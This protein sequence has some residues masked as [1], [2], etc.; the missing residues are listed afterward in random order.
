M[1][2][3]EFKNVFSISEKQINTGRLKE[4]YAQLEAELVNT[5][6]D[7]QYNDDTIWEIKASALLNDL[8][9][10][11][12]RLFKLKEK[13]KSDE[14]YI[15]AS[16][17]TRI[18]Q[19][20]DKLGGNE[21]I[22][23][24]IEDYFT[25]KDRVQQVISMADFEKDELKRQFQKIEQTESSFINSKNVSVMEARLRQLEELYWKGLSNTTSFLI[26][27]FIEYK[28]YTAAEFKDYYAAKSIMKMADDALQK[29][30]YPEFRRH[31]FSISALLHV[32][33]FNSNID[34]KGTGI[35]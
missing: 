15:I 6:R 12:D 11:K 8:R 26:T 33:R 16:R 2:Q 28:T 24:L 7:F 9:S 20:Y 35:G 23:M 19:E 14:K 4:Q 13:D 10:V 1:T 25:N 22:A 3:Q 18:S 17:I 21:R 5:V 30:K 27:C 34:F 32:V 29:E 31:V